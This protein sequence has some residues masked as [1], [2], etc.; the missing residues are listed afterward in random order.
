MTSPEIQRLKDLHH[1]HLAKTRQY[2]DAIKALQTICE[3]SWKY[4]GHGHNEELYVCTVCD[5]EEWR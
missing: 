5:K 2:A 1:E 4:L 3:H